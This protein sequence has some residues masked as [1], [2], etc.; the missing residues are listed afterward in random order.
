MKILLLTFFICLIGIIVYKNFFYEPPLY[1]IT[2]N[3]KIFKTSVIYYQTESCLKLFDHNGLVIC[4]VDFI[5]K[6]K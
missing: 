3:N 4:N 1:I 6:I 2:K 5:R